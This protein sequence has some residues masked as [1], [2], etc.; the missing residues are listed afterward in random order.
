MVMK[1]IVET[2][3]VN[4]ACSAKSFPIEVPDSSVISSLLEGDDFDCDHD[5][6]LDAHETARFS[7]HFGLPVGE[8]ISAVLRP[9]RW[10]DDLPYQIHTNRELALMLDGMKPLAAFSE[11]YP[12][13]TD[14]SVIPEQ[15]FDRYVADGLFLKREYVETE[16]LKGYRTRRILYARSDEAW[17]IDAYIL[18][19]HTAKV[20]G[21]NES[22]ERMEGFLLGYE[23]WQTD[24]YVRAAEARA[25]VSLG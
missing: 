9:R 5:Y 6:E 18:L 17:R 20:T 2:I 22:L 14:E 10:F 8:S 15:L 7:S 25:G 16:I 4:T 19:W 12:S 1:F 24:A 3:D 11:E 23:E 21:W 13:S